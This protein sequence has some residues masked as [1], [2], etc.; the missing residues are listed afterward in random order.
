M[1]DLV[2]LHL[3]H[4]DQCAT[5]TLSKVSEPEQCGGNGSILKE[6]TQIARQLLHQGTSTQPGSSLQTNLT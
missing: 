1:W 3:L 5:N 6:G 4:G 2:D